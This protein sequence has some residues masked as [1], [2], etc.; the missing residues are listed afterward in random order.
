VNL[1]DA[2]A[3][4]ERDHPELTGTA[5]I[6]AIKA[7]REQDAASTAKPAADDAPTPATVVDA[8]VLLA[9]VFIG[10]RLIAWPIWGSPTAGPTWYDVLYV[11]L[12]ITAI[13]AVVGAYRRR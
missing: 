3:Q 6:Q 5:K 2:K 12:L 4:I 9:L 11:V 1:R 8:W 7:L 10:M 13:T